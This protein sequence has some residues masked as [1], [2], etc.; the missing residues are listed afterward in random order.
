MR[1]LTRYGILALLVAPAGTVLPAQR[2]LFRDFG[3]KDGLGNLSVE[4]L[5][6][7][8]AG[9]LWVGTENG[10]FRHDGRRFTDFG[11]SAKLVGTYLQSIHEAPDGALWVGTQYGISRL[12]G[13]RF[14]K[15]PIPLPP[16]GQLFV[17]HGIV[18]D[19]AGRVYVGF[20]E[21]VALFRS[22]EEAAAGRYTVIGFPAGF[23][24]R[25]HS[26]H[27]D[28][29]GTVWVGCG[30]RLCR[31]EPAEQP[32]M[33]Y[34]DQAAGLDEGPW[35]A[36]VSGLDGSLYLRSQDRVYRRL[37]G[38]IPFQDI[39]GELEPVAERRADMIVDSAGA[40]LVTTRNGVARLSGK[41][42]ESVGR[43]D[44]LPSKAAGALLS[45]REGAVWIGTV[46][47]GLLR[48]L[49]YRE[50][51]S[52]TR[53]EGLEDEYVWSVVR[54]GK[55]NMWAG[56][57][58][59]VYRTGP[60]GRFERVATGLG[61]GSNYAL[62]TTAD[63]AVWAGNSDGELVRIDPATGA[64]VQ[65]G[66]AS[67]LNLRIVRRLF[68]DSQRRLWVV[69]SYGAF[70]S[71][72][73]PVSVP[74]SRLRFERMALPSASERDS[75]FDGLLDS[76]GRV[77]AAS[78][79]GLLCLEKDT[80]RRYHHADGLRAGFINSV[81]VD[82][83]G[84]TVWVGYRD[85]GRLSRGRR[86]E[87][88]WK[89]EDVREAGS[90]ESAFVVFLG[91]DA[92]GGLWAGTDRGV[93][94]R[95]RQ[96]W[97]LYTSQDGLVWD[98]CNSR[99]LFAESDGSVWIGT[100]RGLARYQPASPPLPA[101]APHVIITS[102]RL[103]DHI[104]GTGDQP[105]V[106]SKD[107]TLSV[108]IAA[109]SFLNQHSNRF[110][111]RL[112]GSG[113]FGGTFDSGWEETDQS[114]LRYPSLPAGTYRLEALARNSLGAWSDKP[115]SIAFRVKPSW[116]QSPWFYL[117]A[118]VLGS[119]GAAWL[120]SYRNRRHREDRE[121]LEA[122]IADRTSQLQAAKNRAEEA[123]RLKSEFLANVSHEI[124]TPMN[125]I[126]GM[127][128]LALNTELTAEQQDY[129]QTAKSSAD[130]LLSVLNDIL[131]FSKI[132]SGHLEVAAEP[133]DP[134]ECVRDATRSMEASA[135]QKGLELC[136]RIGPE[137]PPAVVGDK[138]R[139]RQVV[140]NLVG[141]AIKFTERGS[142]TVELNCQPT[143]DNRVAMS[144]SVTDTGIGIPAEK[145]A[146]IFDRFRQA[147]GSTTRR[148]GGTGLGLAISKKLVE[149]MGGE[150]TLE[151]EPGKGS[152]F[153]FTLVV[154]IGQL[155]PPSAGASPDRAPGQPLRVL[156]AE[157]NAVNQR[158]VQKLLQRH[159]HFV[160]V[161]NNGAEALQALDRGVFDLVL[162]DVQM[163]VMDGFEATRKLRL[164]EG[165]RQPRTPVIAL[166]ANALKGDKERCL[167]AGMD[168]YL[169]KPVHQDD[170]L[171][172]IRALSACSVERE[173]AEPEEAR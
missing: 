21:G 6:Q 23:S 110:R 27:A 100:S 90:P 16:T 18:S 30:K 152:R 161:V 114:E 131:D 104:Y 112:T 93:Y 50:W 13:D 108:S 98:D 10:L 66:A 79:S 63:G 7:D 130:A 17:K 80:W 146:F 2:Y 155:P 150:I 134:V 74:V 20:H 33:V 124:R 96:R 88:G 170:L 113:L 25:I 171:E 115:A 145:Q 128:Q 123:S 68:L 139:L 48:W 8:S 1:L 92:K 163:P 5:Y 3:Q 72:T 111:Y 60:D 138:L 122:I 46:G 87:A 95:D 14:R 51:K 83:E 149:L 56:A 168:S 82:P 173:A 47:A 67:G 158:V 140:L 38:F 172:A 94:H 57:D 52:W 62:L 118:V 76:K 45:D 12:A 65:I 71:V 127:T 154:P 120:W 125:G 117:T 129:L 49:G 89:W 103:G 40:I 121:R 54:D 147:D 102:F 59:G 58:T 75:V 160:H 133:F 135:I 132:E 15:L 35:N 164:R 28:P 107:N 11:S 143:G 156:L 53:Q 106:S 70:R 78:T 32:R 43:E 29:H 41:N 22:T 166:T 91:T 64:S 34:A 157:D 73:D 116:Y 153:S 126:L 39:T 105:Q 151:S 9:F 162:M 44:G 31:I 37:P 77:W 19:R 24:G 86:T 85:P 42:W 69:G 148:Y 159:G 101:P 169:S 167:E 26:M 137:P 84:E 165:N 119:A 142:V 99:A 4:V 141:N 55:G 61:K 144:L 81:A 97:R 109:L 136:V 36:I